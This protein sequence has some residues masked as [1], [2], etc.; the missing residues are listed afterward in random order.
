MGSAVAS[1]GRDFPISWVEIVGESCQ[2]RKPI[3]PHT[4]K[5]T[6]VTIIRVTLRKNMKP[7][8]IAKMVT[9]AV[10]RLSWGMES[11]VTGK[12]VWRNFLSD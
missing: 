4:T 1:H 5:V 7:A 2:M 8:Q 12:K 10:P 6:L 9:A 11:G 3:Q